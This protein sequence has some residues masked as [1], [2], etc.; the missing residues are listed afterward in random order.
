MNVDTYFAVSDWFTWPATICGERSNL[1]MTCH[2]LPQIVKLGLPPSFSY[3][4]IKPTWLKV[5]CAGRIHLEEGGM[6]FI[7]KEFCLLE[8]EPK[9][10]IQRNYFWCIFYQWLCGFGNIFVVSLFNEDKLSSYSIMV[11]TIFTT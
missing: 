9:E 1:S 2:N 4:F 11:K 5:C 7:S 8:L 10:L 6:E 3:C